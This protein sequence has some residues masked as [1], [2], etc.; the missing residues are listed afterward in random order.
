MPVVPFHEIQFPTDISQACEGGPQFSTRVVT[1]ASGVEQRIQQWSRSRSK[2]TFG[3]ED[4][5]STAV[6]IITSF[7]RCRAG[8]AYGFRWKDWS[9]YQATD[10]VLVNPNPGTTMQL[11]KTYTDAGGS[12]VRKIKKPVAGTVTLK[13]NGVAFASGGNWTINTTTGV[14]TLLAVPSG[15]DAF[16]WSGEFDIPVRF[17][18]DQ[19]SFIQ[20][21]PTMYSANGLSVVELL[22]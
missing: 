19:F 22:L 9:D 20:T 13:K 17:N 7:F 12:E 15:G 21:A 1:G 14:I 11:Q 16:T 2:W 18:E 4:R 8:R 6:M 10:Q 5:S 3:Y